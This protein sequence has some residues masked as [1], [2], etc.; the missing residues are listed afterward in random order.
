MH[1]ET[2]NQGQGVDWE[3]I[4]LLMNA[5]ELGITIEQ[6]REFFLQWPFLNNSQE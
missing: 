2:L 3:W 5:R 6:I 1:K 4:Q